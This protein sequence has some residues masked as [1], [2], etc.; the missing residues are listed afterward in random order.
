MSVDISFGALCPPLADQL[1]AGT[2]P[3]ETLDHLQRDA[4]AITRL[5]VRGLLT[6]AQIH[7]ARSKLVKK[8]ASA[9]SG[10]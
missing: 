7:A 10:R 6:D 9:A 8:I 3:A 2:I 5:A 4:D 1:P